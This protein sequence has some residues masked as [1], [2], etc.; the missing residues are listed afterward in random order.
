MKKTNI[1]K[2]IEQLEGEARVL[3]LAIEKL[4]QQQ[5]AKPAKVKKSK[6]AVAWL[7]RTEQVKEG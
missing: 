6:P 3:Q 5:I 4:R 2:A 7:D 1:D